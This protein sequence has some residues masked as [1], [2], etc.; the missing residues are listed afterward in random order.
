MRG[1]RYVSASLAPPASP[2]LQ[3][4]PTHGSKPVYCP[5]PK[6]P[7]AHPWPWDPSSILHINHACNLMQS[8]SPG[9]AGGCEVLQ[10]LAPRRARPLLTVGRYLCPTVQDFQCLLPHLS[11]I[12]MCAKVVHACMLISLILLHGD[13]AHSVTRITV[14]V[15][16]DIRLNQASLTVCVPNGTSD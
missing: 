5:S 7:P 16:V 8:T 6:S 13:E 1:R 14:H 2:H 4:A 3:H 11:H 9:W 10:P 12:R 15:N